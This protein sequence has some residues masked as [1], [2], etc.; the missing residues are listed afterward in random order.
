M[1]FDGSWIPRKRWWDDKKRRRL[2]WVARGATA[3][4][5][6]VGANTMAHWAGWSVWGAMAYWFLSFVAYE[7]AIDR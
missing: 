7:L 6:I 3:G 5:L 2:R 4:F 1:P